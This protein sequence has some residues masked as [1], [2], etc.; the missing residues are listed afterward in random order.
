MVRVMKLK[1]MIDL[2]YLI[3]G[4]IYMLSSNLRFF[5]VK[6]RVIE[7]GKGC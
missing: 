2:R 4:K 5:E 3:N 6:G 7:K 1:F